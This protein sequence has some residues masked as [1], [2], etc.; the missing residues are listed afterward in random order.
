MKIPP[1]YRCKIETDLSREEVKHLLIENTAPTEIFGKLEEYLFF[2]GKYG[3]A[4]FQMYPIPR[5]VP[6]YGKKNSLLPKI[7][8]EMEE[9]QA[10]TTIVHITV[11]GT[12]IYLVIFLVFGGFAL[13]SLLRG[14]A[15]GWFDIIFVLLF[16]VFVWGYF[17]VVS[18]KIVEMMKMLLNNA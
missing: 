14:Q 16:M 2:M 4:S 11:H 1:I 13:D 15:S 6:F 12:W 5:K 18:K 10:G 7:S 17:L 3:E 9:T 8:G